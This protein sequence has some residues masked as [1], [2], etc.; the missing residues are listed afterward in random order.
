MAAL[1]RP[2]E[3]SYWSQRAEWLQWQ[4]RRGRLSRR[5]MLQLVGAGTIAASLGAATR[6]AWGDHVAVVK[7]RAPPELFIDHGTNREMRWEAMAGQGYHTPTHLFYVRNHLDP[8]LD[9]DT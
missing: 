8:H 2:D 7:P 9:R 5:H 3:G 4:L 6:P 1:G